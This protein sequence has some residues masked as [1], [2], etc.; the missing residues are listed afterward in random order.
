MKTTIAAVIGVALL[1]GAQVFLM[2]KQQS[3]F[4]IS[5]YQSGC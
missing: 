1:M 4:A 5:P 3:A 2:E